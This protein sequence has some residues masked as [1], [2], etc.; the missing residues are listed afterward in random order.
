MQNQIFCG[1]IMYKFNT[2]YFLHTQG[3]AGAPRDY[4][5]F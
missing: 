5:N 2:E 1:V 4:I 3:F